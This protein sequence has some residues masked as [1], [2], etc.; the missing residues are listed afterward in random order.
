MDPWLVKLKCLKLAARN[1]HV[2]AAEVVESARQ[3]YDWIMDRGDAGAVSARPVDTPHK[4]P[5]ST[6]D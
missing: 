1:E 2:S 5:E 6:A 3:F 4:C